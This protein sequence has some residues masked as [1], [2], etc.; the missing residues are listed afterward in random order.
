MRFD[1][2]DRRKDTSFANSPPGRP[3]QDQE[4]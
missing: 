4:R 1:R 3:I 2:L